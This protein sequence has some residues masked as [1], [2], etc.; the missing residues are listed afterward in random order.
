M[1]TH[2]ANCGY[3]TL[4]TAGLL[5]IEPGRY[6][7]S[8]AE[9]SFLEQSRSTSSSPRA[10]LPPSKHSHSLSGS[11]HLHI[12][13]PSNAEIKRRR[14]FR[15]VTPTSTPTP[16]I[17]GSLFNVGTVWLLNRR[18][19]STAGSALQTLSA[20]CEHNGTYHLSQTVSRIKR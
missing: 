11:K 6:T 18:R 4:F 20:S 15:I 9:D 16:P 3:S 17:K 10:V 8:N 5:H 2:I 7:P 13:V 1:T 19:R 12:Q 14:R